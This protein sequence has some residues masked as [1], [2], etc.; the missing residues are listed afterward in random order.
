MMLMISNQDPLSINDGRKHVACLALVDRHPFDSSP[1][2]IVLHDKPCSCELVK[3]NQ[4]LSNSDFLLC[5]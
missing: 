1:I 3:D 2:V 5:T 4:I